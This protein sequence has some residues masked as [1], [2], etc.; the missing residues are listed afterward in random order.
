VSAAAATGE[1]FVHEALFYAGDEEYLA[2]TV[3]FVHAGLEAGEAMMVAVPG[4]RL[5]L[6]RG[7]LDGVGERVRFVDMREFGRNP[8]RLIP[9]W[10]DFLNPNL[11]AGRAVRGIG[12][13]IWAGRT[14]AELE[15]CRRHESLLNLAFAEVPALTLMCPYDTAR[16]G[17]EVLS[18][19][20]HS[21]PAVSGCR[22]RST[23][24]ALPDDAFAGELSR[25]AESA[26]ELSFGEADLHRV[27]H[28]VEEEGRR[29]GLERRRLDD[30]VLA[31]NEVATNSLRHGGGRGTVRVWSED[32]ALVCDFS[33]SGRF[34]APLVGRRRPSASQFGGR[35]L[36]IANQLCDLVQIRSGGAG[37]LVRLRMA[38]G[39][40]V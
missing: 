30:F 16:L 1:G 37:S 13:P 3:A 25:P 6:L 18:E 34:E 32:G 11:A 14:A 22:S 40:V 38:V 20:E 21:H 9:A 5:E 35:G 2:G 4:P 29:G 8:A 39:G 19:A 17:D 23:A 15:E 10:R 12:E 24:Y 26:R 36:W 33:D 27:R 7:S 31:A 28:F